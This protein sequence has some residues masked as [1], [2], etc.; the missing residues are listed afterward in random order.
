MLLIV[1][2]AVDARPA[3]ACGRMLSLLDLFG[4]VLTTAILLTLV[5]S[6]PWF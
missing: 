1:Y 5:R 6:A 2:M 4:V 3:V